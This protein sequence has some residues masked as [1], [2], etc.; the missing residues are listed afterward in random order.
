MRW[1]TTKLSVFLNISGMSTFRTLQLQSKNSAN[2]STSDA[3]K[4]ELTCCNFRRLP[5]FGTKKTSNFAKIGGILIFSDERLNHTDHA[6]FRAIAATSLLFQSTL[7]MSRPFSAP[8]TKLIKRGIYQY[9]SLNRATF[10]FQF[11]LW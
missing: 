1:R 2:Y 3:S 10:S 9:N 7:S 5:H 8:T 4:R 6:A 11:L